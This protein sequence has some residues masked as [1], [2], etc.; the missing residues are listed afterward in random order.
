MGQ[1]VGFRRVQGGL[2]CRISS[3]EFSLEFR[4]YGVGFSLY[5]LA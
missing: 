2:G 5:G 1:V 3:L 4:V